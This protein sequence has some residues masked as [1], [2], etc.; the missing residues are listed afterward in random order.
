MTVAR[1]RARERGVDELDTDRMAIEAGAQLALGP[2]APEL[3]IAG[4]RKRT[5]VSTVH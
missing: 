4:M 3:R 5:V 2:Q 1:L